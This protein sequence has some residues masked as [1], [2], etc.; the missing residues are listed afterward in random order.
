MLIYNLL[1]SYYLFKKELLFKLHGYF[2]LYEHMHGISINIVKDENTEFIPF[3][4]IKSPLNNET[5]YK[6]NVN[7]F[8]IVDDIFNNI[9]FTQ[10]NYY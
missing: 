5:L 8:L 3:I 2:S 10:K 7:V 1:K 9:K 4:L 6:D